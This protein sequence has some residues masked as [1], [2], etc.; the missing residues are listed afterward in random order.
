MGAWFLEFSEGAELDL[1]KLGRPVRR[2]IIR[3]FVISTLFFRCR[4]TASLR[5]SIS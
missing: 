3:K 5:N 1:A 4:S 2:Q